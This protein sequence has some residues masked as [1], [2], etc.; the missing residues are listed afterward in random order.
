MNTV[1]IALANIRSAATADESVALACSAVGEAGKEHATIICFPECYIP[2]YRLPAKKLPSP[3]EAFL[4]RAWCEV[5]RAARAAG[6][7]VVLGTERIVEDRPRITVLVIGADGERVGFQDKVQLDPSEDSFF[8]AGSDRQLFRAGALTFGV[9][10]CHEG[11]RYPETTRWAARRGAHLVFHPHFHETEPGGYRP[12]SFAD[13][14]NTFH[15]KAML[16]RAAEN[17]CYFASVNCASAGSPTTSAVIRPDG[18]V[19]AWQPYGE[20]GLLIAD[21]DTE[22]AT[23][24]LASRCRS[25]V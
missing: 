24:L 1:R 16:C 2:G 15:E 17:S 19:L 13:P 21:I 4:E 23:G 22:A 10:I 20:E 9:T 18:T 7:T 12:T 8:S 3:N 5:A 6:A 25:S 14:L 11:W